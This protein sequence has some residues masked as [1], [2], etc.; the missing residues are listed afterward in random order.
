MTAVQKDAAAN[1]CT[2]I[3]GLLNILVTPDGQ[4]LI[5]PVNNWLTSFC[6]ASDCS[7]DTISSVVQS[8]SQACQTDLANLGVTADDIAQALPYIQQNF[9][10]AKE[11][12]C[13]AECV[14]FHFA[15]HCPA[16]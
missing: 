8:V 15:T 12:I 14:T 1:S 16:A 2:A 3:S 4:S 13:L 5:T 6:G 11:I 10:A 7:S 9:G